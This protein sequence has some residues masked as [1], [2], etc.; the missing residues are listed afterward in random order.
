MYNSDLV[1]LRIITNLHCNNNCNFCYQVD[2][3]KN[4][5][6]LNNLIVSLHGYP[7]K[8]F[9]YCTIMGGESTLLPNL[10]EYIKI[11]SI[12]SKQTRLTTNGKLL[13]PEK[14][15]QYKQ[16]GLNG[17]NISIAVL[18]PSKYKQVHGTDCDV[19]DLIYLVDCG[20]IDYRINIP[21]CKENME[22]D[23]KELKKMLDLFVREGHVN[24]TMCEDIK[25]S[26]SLYE[27]FDKI[28]VKV[29]EETNYGLILLEYHG[30]KIGYYTHRNSVYNETD[31]VVT[32]LGTF[33]NWSS[34]CDAVGF[35]K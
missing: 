28:D 7:Y 5:L 11:G 32:P 8:H 24:V 27:N 15:V 31:L 17:I 23:C 19:D 9:E 2:K 18:N 35:N 3:S 20:T 26:Y 21:L 29:I 12:F 13:T 14:V 22:N 4:V 33:I 10:E 30:Q 6:N 1:G 25:S 16:C 34:Y